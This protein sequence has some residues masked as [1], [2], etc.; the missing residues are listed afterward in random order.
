MTEDIKEHPKDVVYERVVDI[1]S[2]SNFIHFKN[3]TLK[4]LINN[5]SNIYRCRNSTILLE[6]LYSEKLKT[7]ETNND[8]R[9]GNN[10][11]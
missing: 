2:T 1:I 5:F 7:F 3:N 4:R 8:L 10:S 11:E 6:T 9:H